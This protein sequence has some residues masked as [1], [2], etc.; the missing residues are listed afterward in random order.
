[1]T[2][3]L[4]HALTEPLGWIGMIW[5]E[6]DEDKL[7]A[8]GKTWIEYGAKLRTQAQKANEAARQAWTENTGEAME[9]FERW[10]N[11]DQGPGHNLEQAATA[12]ELIGAGLIAMAGVVLA[13][14]LAFIAQLALLAFEVGQAIATAFATFGATTAEIPGFIAAAKYLC[15]QA[16][17]KAL[18]AIEREIGE[19]FAKAAKLL[20]KVGAKNLAADAGKVAERIGERSAFHGLMAE[21]ERAN[22]SSPVNGAN[23]YSG[24]AADG[25]RMR[26][27]A[28]LNTDGVNSVT[29]EKTVGGE[30]FDKM[31][32]YEPG[33]PISKD[34]ADRV[35]SRLSERYAENAEGKVTAWTHDPWDG[36]VWNRTELPALNRNPKVTDIQIIDPSP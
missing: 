10:W 33:S 23:F 12:V 31:G 3:E 17:N 25:T 20:E 1:M 32:L 4:P 18:Q 28:D 9:A 29:L 2:I 6:A 21:V 34:Q 7:F 27:Y 35:W 5:P 24:R 22:V 11:R 15:R 19:L 13:L 8:D 36:S 30:R 26:T 14:K 16:I